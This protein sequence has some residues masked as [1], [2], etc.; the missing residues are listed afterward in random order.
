MICISC[1]V[2]RFSQLQAIDHGSGDGTNDT[3]APPASASP[4]LT[5][6]RRSD[7]CSEPEG[8]LKLETYREAPLF[9]TR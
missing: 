5:K 6:A 4:A 2:S 3:P 1:T 7:S 9:V 8:D